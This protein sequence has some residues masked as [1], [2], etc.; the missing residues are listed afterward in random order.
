MSYYF[1]L[2]RKNSLK[3]IF[4]T[5]KH[6]FNILRYCKWEGDFK[7]SLNAING[8]E[9]DQTVN[10]YI[11]TIKPRPITIDMEKV[12]ALGLKPGPVIGVLKK[13]MQYKFF[14]FQYLKITC[15]ESI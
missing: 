13:G 1:I 15:L 2:A 4:F 11:M 14:I 7:G 8:V 10:S 6:H 3:Y 9:I 12:K 5:K